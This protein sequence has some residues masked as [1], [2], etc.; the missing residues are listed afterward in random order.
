M[1][2]RGGADTYLNVLVARN[3]LLNSRLT[4]ISLKLSSLQNA[5]TPYTALGGGWTEESPP[6]TPERAARSRR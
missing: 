1:R 5:I 4:L 2:F 3:S 6:P